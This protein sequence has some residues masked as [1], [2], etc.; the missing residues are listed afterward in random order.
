MLQQ[1]KQGRINS[2][3]ENEGM[4]AEIK[5]LNGVVKRLKD[6]IGTLRR[7]KDAQDSLTQQKSVAWNQERGQ[8][9]QQLAEAK[10][11]FEAIKKAD[12]ALM[13]DF[14]RRVQETI[15]Q[16]FNDQRMQDPHSE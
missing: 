6:D 10:Q 7:E 1:E 13:Q 16:V 14:E 9:L 15:N 5:D 11:Q 2:E 8:I 4:S 3:K 12:K